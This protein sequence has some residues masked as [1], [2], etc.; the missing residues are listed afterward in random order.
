M[1]ELLEQRAEIEKEIGEPLVWNAHPERQDKIIAIYRQADLTEREKWP[2]HLD[3]M[4][5]RVERFRAVFGL[6]I[7][8]FELEP[9]DE[10]E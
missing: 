5:D 2:G 3:W 6:R 8:A 4:V 1:A 10:G 9:G 7:K